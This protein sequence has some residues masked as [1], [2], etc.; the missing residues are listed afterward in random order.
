MV[1]GIKRCGMMMG[2]HFGNIMG[3]I[4]G[5]GGD[6]GFTIRGSKLIIDGGLVIGGVVGLVD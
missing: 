1:A 3:S 6:G 4:I 2:N 5:L